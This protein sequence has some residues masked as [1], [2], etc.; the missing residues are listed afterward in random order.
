MGAP[1]LSLGGL[2]VLGNI[3]EVTGTQIGA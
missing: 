1:V 2:V 3:R